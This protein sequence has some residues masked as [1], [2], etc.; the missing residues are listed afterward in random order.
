VWE[1]KVLKGSYALL[2]ELKEDRNIKVGALGRIHFPKG[3]YVYVGSAM[4]GI[5]GRVRRHLRSDKKM[6]WHIDYLLKKS[7]IKE[8]FHLGSRGRLECN[9]AKKFESQCEVVPKFGS[10]DCMCKGHL[11]YG[12]KKMLE[13]CVLDLGLEEINIVDP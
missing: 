13:D 10:S 3:Y 11:F 4:N 2:L 8:V 1:V 5:E 12:S 6:H 9:I 7:K